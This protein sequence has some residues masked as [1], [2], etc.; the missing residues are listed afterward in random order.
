MRGPSHVQLTQARL[1]AEVQR[2]AASGQPL[3]GR[4]NLLI[5]GSDNDKKFANYPE[6][7]TQVMIVLSI[8][9]DHHTAT[10]LSIPRDF[11]VHIPGYGYNYAPDGSG[12]IGWSK[13]MVASQLG[14]PSAACTVERNFGIAINHWVWVGLQGFIKVIDTLNGVTLDVPHPVIDDTYPDDT[15]GSNDPNGYRRLYIPPG[16]QRLSGAN[17]LRFVRSRHGDIQGDFGRSA[18]QQLLLIQLRHVLFAQNGAAIVAEAVPLLRD[19]QTEMRTDQTIDFNTAVTYYRLLQSVA[20]IKLTQVIL[21][22]PIYSTADVWQT[23]YDPLHVIPG[24]RE[25]AVAPNWTAINPEIVQL[26]GGQN[27]SADPQGYCK[28]V[29]GASS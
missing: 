26:F 6:P 23:D 15:N 4:V 22:P 7:L 3:K 14:F 2:A 13:I 25:V 10:L 1:S 11:W 16:P 19:F 29:P 8:D 18:R 21:S 12:S 17:A 20:H 5:L 28:Q 24:T 9:T 27:T